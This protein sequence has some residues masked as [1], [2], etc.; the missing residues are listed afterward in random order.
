MKSL[1]SSLL[2]LLISFPMTMEAKKI[3]KEE[4]AEAVSQIF[5][6]INSG[7]WQITIQRVSNGIET[8][9]DL[10][11]TCN[12]LYVKDSVKVSQFDFSGA[13]VY[14]MGKEREPNFYAGKSSARTKPIS[15]SA[16]KYALS[17]RRVISS[18][19]SANKK[20]TVV[21]L[22][23]KTQGEEVARTI[24]TIIYIDPISLRANFQN[25]DARGTG[26]EYQGV[27][28]PLD[29]NLFKL[30]PYTFETVVKK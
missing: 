1:I 3:T 18:E 6:I 19:L 5:E 2:V 30:H 13:H 11:P 4:R 14:T 8:F 28:R 29:P 15:G 26:F 24:T 21:K 12:F 27:V 10:V 25:R 20:N 22:V 9:D 7:Q 23:L 16:T 17:Q